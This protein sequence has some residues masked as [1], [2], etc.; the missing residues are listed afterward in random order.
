MINQFLNL[1]G[2]E[3]TKVESSGDAITASI[4]L[5]CQGES[6]CPKCK[7]RMVKDGKRNFKYLD[8]PMG[9]QHVYLSVERVKCVCPKCKE[10]LYCPSDF[11][12]EKRKATVRLVEIIQHKCLSIPFCEL[13]MYTGLDVSIIRSIAQE[14]IKEL[15]STVYFCTPSII[16]INRLTIADETRYVLTNV[17]KKAIF[18]II[19]SKLDVTLK[20]FLKGLPSRKGVTWVYQDLHL[21]LRELLHTAFPNSRSVVHKRKVIELLN[22]CMLKECQLRQIMLNSS[23]SNLSDR[24]GKIFTKKRRAELNSI[25]KRDLQEV[26][27]LIPSLYKAYNFREDFLSIYEQDDAKSA[28]LSMLLWAEEIPPELALLTHF[29][30]MV[31]S[32]L[33]EIIAYWDAPESTN[34]DYLDCYDG[35]REVSNYI[36]NTTNY[37]IV[38]AR[39]LY[40]EEARGVTAVESVVNGR[41]EYGA[42]I[43]VLRNKI[44]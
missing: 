44:N 4:V 8:V 42:S 40:N 30:Q 41:V 17:E 39:M 16:G 7:T 12:D 18:A 32:C 9:L 6:N 14:Y 1:K 19:D 21:P 24:V 35:L 22:E 25:D 43:S 33:I 29:A 38:R 2:V 3:V 36:G 20:N 23:K 15:E 10:T 13:E 26:A 11:I 31:K 37:N 34:Q 27:K 28:K 5:S